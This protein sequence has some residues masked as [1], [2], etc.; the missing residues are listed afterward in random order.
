[1]KKQEYFRP[2]TRI[3][4]NVLILIIIAFLLLPVFGF[5]IGLGL[6]VGATMWIIGKHGWISCILT[7]IITAIAIH[8]IFGHW[9]DIPLPTG[10]IGW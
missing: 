1:M 8:F 9:L 10:L 5:S 4:I 2:R 3:G 7:T 6:Y